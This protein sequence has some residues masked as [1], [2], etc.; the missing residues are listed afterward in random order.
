[1]PTLAVVLVFLERLKN[2]L[3]QNSTG[4]HHLQQRARQRLTLRPTLHPSSSLPCRLDLRSQVSQRLEPKEPSLG[5]VRSI[6]PTSRS[7]PHG[8]TTI[9]PPQLGSQ[10]HRVAGR[11]ADGTLLA[12]SPTP[13]CLQTPPIRR[14]RRPTPYRAHCHL[15]S[16]H[17][18]RSSKYANSTRHL[19]D[20]C[21]QAAGCSSLGLDANVG[22]RYGSMQYRFQRLFS[23]IFSNTWSPYPTP[24]QRLDV[25]WIRFNRNSRGE[26][27]VACRIIKDQLSR[28]CYRGKCRS[29]S[30]RRRNVFSSQDD[31]SQVDT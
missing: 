28:D 17:A 21:N 9:I 11:L 20:S 8:A 19:R 25:E 4:K 23:I 27:R 15:S 26:A 7:Q 24:I 3:P 16:N 14:P 1:M 10:H 5:Q 2:V 31:R 22:T 18:S 13:G 30:L 6:L 29:G 12:I